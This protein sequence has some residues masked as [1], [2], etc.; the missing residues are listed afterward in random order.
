M[1]HATTSSQAPLSQ[2]DIEADDGPCIAA[3][4]LETFCVLALPAISTA[5]TITALVYAFKA[6]KAWAGWL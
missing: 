1:S 2:A 6:L 4:R 3:I 5:A